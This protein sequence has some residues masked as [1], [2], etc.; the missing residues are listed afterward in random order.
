MLPWTDRKGKLA[1]LKLAVF[2]GTLL[3]ALWL[4]WQAGTGELPAIASTGGALGNLGARP[5]NEAIHQTGET[6]PKRSF[7]R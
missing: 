4:A 3:P 5:I 7:R 2:V 6:D 1:P